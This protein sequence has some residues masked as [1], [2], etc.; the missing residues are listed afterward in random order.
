MTWTVRF[1]VEF[2]P[3]F[4]TLSA[5]VRIELLA[6][7]KVLEQFGPQTGRIAGGRRQIGRQRG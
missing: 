6:Q 5:A 2:E 4:A 1:A 7:A 3:E